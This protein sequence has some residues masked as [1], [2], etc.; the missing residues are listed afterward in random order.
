MP[1]PTLNDDDRAQRRRQ[2]L[3]AAHALYQRRQALPTVAEIAQAA[4]VAKGTVYLSF[5]TKEEIFIA[6]LDDGFAQLLGTLLPQ[7]QQLPRQAEAAAA[8]FAAGFSASL[9]TLP[10]LLPLAAMTNSVLEKNLPLD[11]LLDFKTRVMGGL[12]MAGA[13][14]E[15]HLP[16]LLEPDQGSDLLRR[17]WALTQGLWQL[18][19]CPTPMKPHLIEALTAR[20]VPHVYDRDFHDELQTALTLLWR[21]TL[22]ARRR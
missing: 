3:D 14:L 22:L 7:L 10:D 5:G 11:T 19:D 4:G 12:M 21:G 17:T 6:L 15:A 16:L 13:Q 20:G 18:S 2:L 9:R 8:A 1:R